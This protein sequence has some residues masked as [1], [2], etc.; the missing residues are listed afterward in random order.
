MIKLVIDL[1]MSLAKMLNINVNACWETTI[2]II[3]ISLSIL[4][5]VII[6]HEILFTV[7]AISGF[8]LTVRFIRYKAFGLRFKNG[9]SRG[10]LGGKKDKNE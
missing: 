6:G 10:K 1:N 3:L 7:F 8:A 9:D 5:Y 4:I 2:G